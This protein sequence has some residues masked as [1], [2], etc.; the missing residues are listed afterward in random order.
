MVEQAFGN[1]TLAEVLAE[2]TTSKPLCD[3][4]VTLKGT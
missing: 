1:S 2:P 3:F 4:P